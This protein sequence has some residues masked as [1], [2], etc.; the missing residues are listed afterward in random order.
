MQKLNSFL[1]AVNQVLLYA[2][3]ILQAL[4]SHEHLASKYGICVRKYGSNNVLFL[5]QKFQAMIITIQTIEFSQVCAHHQNG[6]FE[7]A[8]QDMT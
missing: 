4:C 5:A 6:I 3:D 7:K 1:H 8:I 2:E